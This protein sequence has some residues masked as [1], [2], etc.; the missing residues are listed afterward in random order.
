MSLTPKNNF[1][2]DTIIAALGSLS[3]LSYS[4]PHDY[5]MSVP[6]FIKGADIE[7]ER[8]AMDKLR[9]YT[10]IPFCNY[11]CSY[12]FFA[13]R[14][15]ADD[16]EKARYVKALKREL[17]WIEPGIELS[18]L[19]IG[20]GTPTALPPKLFNQV[21]ESIFKKVSRK[22]ENIHTVETSPESLT[23]DHIS[24]LQEHNIG[25]VSMG[26][27]TMDDSVLNG[28]NRLHTAKQAHQAIE[29]LLDAG[30]I[31]NVDLIYGLPGQTYEAFQYDLE[32]LAA[33][34]IQSFTI[35]N[36]RINERTPIR[37]SLNEEE[38][39]DLSRL[40]GWRAFI[41]QAT[42]KLGYEQTRW[43]TFKRMDSI[44]GNHERA[45]H[46]SNDGKG[47]QLGV[48]LSA[49]SQ[50]GYNIYRNTP[51]MN[52]YLKQVEQGLSPVEDYMPLTIEDRKTQYIARSIGDGKP[53]RRDAYLTAFGTSFDEDFSS[54][55]QRLT[56]NDILQDRG[57]DLVLTDTG[58]LV[59]DLVTV[60]FYP[61]HALD[62]L[63]NKHS[64]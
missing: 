20:G 35:Y 8:P 16:D 53:F 48:G 5:P 38:H 61:Q 51:H 7:R 33:K 24:I 32:M 59:Y 45:P 12:C 4:P 17:E 19:F 62:W 3:G 25:R 40:M 64:K 2:I 58:K 14:I 1:D 44:A 13:K 41:K 30:F 22:N 60:A 55:I 28:V 57:E 47:Y 54:S 18:Q 10:H 36:L 9:L 34:N 31:L 29:S 11:G 49:R 37:K 39:A 21:F 46:F 15:G 42:L 6:S 63:A 56:D 50:L 23:K 26:I 52:A 27:Q 43:H